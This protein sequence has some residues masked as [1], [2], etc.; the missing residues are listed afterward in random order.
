MFGYPDFDMSVIDKL[1]EGSDIVYPERHN[2]FKSFKLCTFEKVKVVILGQDPY[3]GECQA[4]GLAFSVDKHCKIPPSLRNILIEISNN[5]GCDK[6]VNGDFTHIA[7]KGV[8]F[9]NCALTVK[10]NC[11]LSHINIWKDYTN[12]VI[13]SINNKENSVIFLLWGNYAKLKSK[14]IDNAKHIVLE[15][16]H[17]SPMSANRGL[18][19]GNNHF[20][21]VN[22]ILK[23]KIF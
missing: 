18:W 14:M 9:L 4:N 8:L 17:P 19:F 2:I 1:Y 3:H 22:D 15:T 12:A 23:E 10:K 16:G 11:P 21:Q 13:K 20:A 6:P 5:E 7:E